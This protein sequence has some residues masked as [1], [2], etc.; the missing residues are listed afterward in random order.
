MYETAKKKVL[1]LVEGEKRDVGVMEKLFGVYPELDANYQI[2]P[3]RT[4][5][6]VLYN[7]YF[8][9]NDTPGDLD[10][11]QILKSRE[12]DP[13]QKKIFDDRY[14]DILLIFDLDPHDTMFTEEKIR[15]LQA[16]FCESS[17]MGKLY[18]SYPMIEAFYHMSDIPDDDYQNR[19]VS[20]DELQQKKYKERVHKETRGNDYNKYITGRS[21]LNYVVL[22]NIRKAYRLLEQDVEVVNKWREIDLSGVLDKQLGFLQE[23][24]LHVLCT[25]VIYIYDYNCELLFKD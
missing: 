22:E 5:I 24:Y 21:D 1:V 16:H 3:Y 2:V 20:I 19:T 4:N 18:L 10:L 14:T 23:H 13:E 11:L 17:D 6:Y 7:D 8:N 9:N 12:Q 25:C 15:R